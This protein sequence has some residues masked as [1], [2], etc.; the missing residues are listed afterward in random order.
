MA[1]RKRSSRRPQPKHKKSTKSQHDK[2]S[3]L[4]QRD[5]KRRKTYRAKIPLAGEMKK[6]VASMQKVVDR[7]D[8]A[9]VDTAQ[10]AALVVVS[11]YGKLHYLGRA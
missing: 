10:P 11:A 3:R 8:R 4:D 6:A 1:K 2:R 7:P 5:E 9:W